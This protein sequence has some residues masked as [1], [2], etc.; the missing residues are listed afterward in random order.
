M[1]QVCKCSHGLLVSL[2]F[3][4]V[5]RKCPASIYVIFFLVW[6]FMLGP[7]LSVFLGAA[8]PCVFSRTG[9][10]DVGFI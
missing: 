4:V 1:L 8:E 5:S 7:S 2:V 9:L 10:S 6:F 3:K